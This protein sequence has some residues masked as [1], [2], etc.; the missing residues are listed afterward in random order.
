MSKSMIE[1]A[2]FKEYLCYEFDSYKDVDN[3]P[4]KIDYHINFRESANLDVDTLPSVLI[5]KMSSKEMLYLIDY[6]S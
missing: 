3:T 5:D 2:Y 4:R 6:K 1:Q